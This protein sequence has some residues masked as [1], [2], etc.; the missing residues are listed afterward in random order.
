MV[1]DVLKFLVWVYQAQIVYST[2]CLT[3]FICVC[4]NGELEVCVQCWY[5]FQNAVSVTHY[6]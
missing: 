6:K 2:L 4:H 1:I 5:V 3:L